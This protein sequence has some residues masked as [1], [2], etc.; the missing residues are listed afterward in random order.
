MS[1]TDDDLDRENLFLR[2]ALTNQLVTEAQLDEC[3]NVAK[4]IAAL[5]VR[6]KSV[7]EILLEKGLIAPE[8]WEKIRQH[9]ERLSHALCIPGYRLQQKLGQGSMGTVY[10]ALQLSL[11]RTV[12]IKILAPFLADNRAFVE[13]FLREAK[14][15]ARLNHPNVVQGIDVGSVG[16]LHYF[17]MEY[18]DGPTVLSLIRQDGA[19]DEDRAVGIIAH[20][21]RALEHAARHDIVHRDIKPDNIMIVEGGVAKLCDLGLAKELSAD[22]S[23]SEAG[24]AM[25]TPNYISPEQARGDPAIDRRSDIYS[26]GATFYHMLTGV[27]PFEGP[28]AA[29]VMVKHI[30]EPPL[31][32]R[33]RR[34]DIDPETERIVL[35]MLSKRPEYRHQTP[36][37]LLDE[38]EALAERRAR[39][40]RKPSRRRITRARRRYRT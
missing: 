5:G 32:P 10:K 2:I 18:C 37:E 26:L 8:A 12:A 20:V 9:I 33:K 19:L 4:Q 7:P 39:G 23:G 38:L 24:A 1:A 25:G 36:T 27:P 3:R 16:G 17:V 28:S 40:V 34:P 14:A 31:P 6:R 22:G 13:R 29:V 15:L 30:S 35:R 11:D 21:A